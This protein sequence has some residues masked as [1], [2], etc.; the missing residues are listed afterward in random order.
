MFFETEKEAFEAYA[1]AL[2]NNCIFLVDTYDSVDGIRHAIEVA[3]QL[4]KEGHEMIG[5]RLDS[6]DGVAL[7]I[8]ARRMLDEAGLTN[9]KIVCSSDLDEHVIADMKQRGAKI[10]IWGVGT[11]LITG[12]PDAALGGIYKLG[13]V[14][15]PGG[16][17]QYRIKLSDEL[18]KTSYPGL[19][20]VR[21][22]RQPDGRFIADA[23][24]ETNHPISEPCVLIDSEREKKTEIPAKTEHSDLLAPVF[25]R[26]RLV[27]QTQNIEASREHARQQLSCAAPEILRLKNPTA[28]TIGLERSL[29][30]LR[31]TLIAHA[32]EQMRVN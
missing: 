29:H 6:G 13:A 21:R 2:P 10:D 12:Q 25:R 9:A 14:R 22:F 16:Q 4:R 5:V 15:R 7:S 17:W 20:Q 3:G 28:Y 23:I 27:Y 19:L 26:G 32:K 24:Y 30:E 31:S 18:A 1:R 8:E 11:R